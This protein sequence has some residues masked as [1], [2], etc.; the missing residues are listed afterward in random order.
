MTISGTSQSVQISS[1]IQIAQDAPPVLKQE[2]T[3]V[4]AGVE[5][6]KKA[7]ESNTAALDLLMSTVNG[8]GGQLDVRA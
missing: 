3:A 4:A 2:A 1:A 8:L 7:N 5:A 6:L